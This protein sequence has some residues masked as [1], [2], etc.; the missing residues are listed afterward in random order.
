[1]AWCWP[2]GLSSQQRFADVRAQITP[3]IKEIKQAY[4][5]GIADGVT[6]NP[7]LMKK[8]VQIRREAGENVDIPSYINQILK[9]AEGTPVSLEVTAISAEGQAATRSA[10]M[11]RAHMAR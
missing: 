9:T 11:L 7:S 3:R 10:P 2:R 1:M 6:T 8:A 4:D 5:W